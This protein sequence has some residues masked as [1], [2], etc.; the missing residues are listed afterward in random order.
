[1]RSRCA[2][3]IPD[4]RKLGLTDLANRVLAIT[5]SVLSDDHPMRVEPVV[6]PEHSLAELRARDLDQLGIGYCRT[7]LNQVRS[8]PGPLK[9]A[10]NLATAGFP[11]RL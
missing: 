2:F 9:R 4:P 3:R 8:H 1:M 6:L 11:N 5:V 7:N 10:A